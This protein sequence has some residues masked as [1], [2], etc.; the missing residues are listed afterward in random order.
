MVEGRRERNTK[1]RCSDGGLGYEPDRCGLEI[2][3]IATII[4]PVTEGRL[5]SRA[6]ALAFVANFLHSLALFG[7]LQLPGFLAERDTNELMI[8]VVMGT[9]AA[10]AVGLRPWVGRLLD[11]RGRRVVARWGSMLHLGV[12]LAYLG[13]DAVGPYLFVVRI[14]HGVAQAMLFSTLFTIAADVVPASRRTEGIALFG[15]SG[16]LPMSLA[17]LMGDAILAHADYYALFAATAIV[18]ALAG[19][20]SWMLPDSRPPGRA[21]ARPRRSF[22]TTVKSPS[23]RPLWLMTF[24][25]SFA[26]ASYFTFLR[27]FIDHLGF[28]SMGLFYTVYS[29]AAVVLRVGLGW[30]PDRI[31]ARRTL[32]PAIAATVGGLWVLSAVSS[33][34]GVGVAGLLCGMGHAFVF[35][36]LSALVVTR[37]DEHE[38]GAALSGFTALFDLGMLVGAP[39]LGAVLQQTDYTT[40]FL[41]AAAVT[42]AGALGFWAYDERVRR[43]G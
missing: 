4:S 41:G 10:A 9:M 35:P 39:V 7:Y 32:V 5:F 19:V 28:G 12:T 1:D 8:G 13:V 40:M 24:S 42:T 34:L 25:F 36:I 43:R 17:G 26:L 37:A 20:C 14:V 23:L 27:T 16:L 15:V 30:V 18:A 38:R 3:R 22:F 31:G 11:T 6:F 29:A 21:D 33:D 2:R